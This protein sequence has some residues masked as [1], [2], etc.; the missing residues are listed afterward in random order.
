MKHPKKH[1]LYPWYNMPVSIQKLLIRGPLIVKYYLL[2]IGIYLE[3]AQ[4]ISNYKK[5][6][7]VNTSFQMY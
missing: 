6:V 7:I 2:P 3:E 4:E 1:D 5:S